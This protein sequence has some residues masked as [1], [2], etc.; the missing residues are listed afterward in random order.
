MRIVAAA[1]VVFLSATSAFAQFARQSTSGQFPVSGG[2]G[3]ATAIAATSAGMSA[4]DWAEVTTTGLAST[5]APSGIGALSIINYA[6]YLLWDPVRENLYYVGAEHDDSVEFAWYEGADNEWSKIP[7]AEAWAP[8]S[9]FTNHGNDHGAFD[10]TRGEIYF[11]VFNNRT[12][13]RYDIATA[14]W[15]DIPELPAGLLWDGW[16]VTSGLAWWPALDSVV[17]FN[18]DRVYRYNRATNTWT[19]L[20]TLA[21]PQGYQTFAEYNETEN[22]LLFGGGSQGTRKIWKMDASFTVTPLGDAPVDLLMT[23]RTTVVTSDPVTGDF[24]ILT[25]DD[26]PEEQYCTSGEDSQLRSYDVLTDTWTLEPRGDGVVYRASYSFAAAA[27]IPEYGVTAFVVMFSK[28]V[29]KMW[30]YKHAD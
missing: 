25:C 21:A 26:Q 24:L 20:A 22:V 19:V 28:V 8:W 23:G 5:F 14:T 10:P 9:G 6:Q 3:I 1:L 11:Q 4:G 16:A 18:N 30:L 17:L 7:M 29:G 2:G 15:S 13:R 27:P 12:L